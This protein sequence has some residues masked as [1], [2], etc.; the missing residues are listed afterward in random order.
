MAPGS[1]EVAAMDSFVE[2]AESGEWE[3]IVLDTA[4]TGHTLRLLELPEVV[5]TT[6]E[7][8]LK[9]RGQVRSM[10]DSARSM[11]FGPAYYAFGG[12]SEDEETDDFAAMKARME[13]VADLLRDPERTE[14][15][16][17][18]VPETMAIRETERLV[19]RL[20]EFAV[21]V[22]TLVVNRVLRDVDADE[23]CD[24]CRARRDAHRERLAEIRE[25]FPGLEM[26][27]VPE[28]VG[29]VHGAESLARVG[30]H[31]GV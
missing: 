14:F 10:A 9:V 12:R 11:V 27:T 6:M 3:T 1:D 23:Q 22:E 30:D 19:E 18:L 16:V 26:Q 4:P 31:L 24:R 21:P 29:E 17:V 20:R 2:Y 28:F 7:K 13:R 8:T 15:R 25:R 5:G